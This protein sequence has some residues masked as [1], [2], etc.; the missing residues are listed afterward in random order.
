MCAHLTTPF[1]LVTTASLPMIALE[2]F[3]LRLERRDWS[4]VMW[5]QINVLVTWPRPS[6]FATTPL[7][8]IVLEPF[9][10][11]FE[12]H[13][14][15]MWKGVAVFGF[16]YLN[17]RNSNSNA[18]QNGCSG[19]GFF[20]ELLVTSGH[21]QNVIPRLCLLAMKVF[22]W[23]GSGSVDFVTASVGSLLL[24]PVLWSIHSAAFKLQQQNKNP[25]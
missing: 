16:V 10:L 17:E 8:M 4:N 5:S 18:D 7:P 25:G 19:L 15:R 2:P 3:L 12:S 13:V 14:T 11:R 1:V 6:C 20:F 24:G 23:L 9:V 22:W 21:V